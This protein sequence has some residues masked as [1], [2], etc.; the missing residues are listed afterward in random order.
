MAEIIMHVECYIKREENNTDK[1]A[2]MLK[3]RH[4]E[5]LI[6]RNDH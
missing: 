6:A 5:T 4:V 1:K 2:E 3:N